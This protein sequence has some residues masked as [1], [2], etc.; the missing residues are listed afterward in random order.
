MSFFDSLSISSSGL[1]SQR[2]RMN[3]I[4]SN[5]AN[6]NTTRTPEG[7]PYRRKELVVQAA[8]F[9]TEFT[10]LVGSGER[11]SPAGVKVVDIVADQRA[12]V[13]KF[14]PG[15]P[16]ADGEGYVAYPNINVIEE[17]VNMMTAARS[18]EANVAAVTTAKSM[19]AKALEIGR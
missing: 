6:A 19:V 9:A 2:L 5:L 12:P 1:S 11:G 4:S 7:G 10:R 14:D 13:T 3:L 8:P 16:D 18:Y 17:M 15:H